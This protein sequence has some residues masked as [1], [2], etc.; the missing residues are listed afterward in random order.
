MNIVIFNNGSPYY[1]SG[2]VGLDLFKEFQKRGHNVKLLVN[3]YSPNYPESVISVESF[4]LYWQKRVL[5][6]LKEI[7]NL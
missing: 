3:G 6:K 4:C 2:I 7:L 1:S 5:N